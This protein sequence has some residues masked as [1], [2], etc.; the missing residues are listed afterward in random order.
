MK[1]D[2]RSFPVIEGGGDSYPEIKYMDN[3]IGVVDPN[4]IM[5]AMIN[6]RKSGARDLNNDLK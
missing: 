1:F 3:G 6:F 2:A 4:R 5:E